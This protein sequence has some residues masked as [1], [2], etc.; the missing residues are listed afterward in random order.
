[1]TSYESTRVRLAPHDLAVRRLSLWLLAGWTA[2]IAS[3]SLYPFDVQ[4]R[5]LLDAVM[6]G[7]PKLREWRDP[8]QR[9]TIV[10]LL[11]YLP[12]GLL[13]SMALEKSR[14][15]FIR[16]LWPVCAAAIVSLA[17]E[18]TQHALPVRDPSLA[19][20]VFNNVSA[21]LGTLV[22][23]LYSALPVQPLSRRLQRLTIGPAPALLVALWLVAHLAPFVPRLR[24]GRIEAAIETSLAMPFEAGK[25]FGFF[26][27]YLVLGTLLNA[28]L[29]RPYFWSALLLSFGV[30]LGAR[31]LFVGQHL[32]PAEGAALVLSLVAIA[33]MR[34]INPGRWASQAFLFACL[35]LFM[36]GVWPSSQPFVTSAEGILWLPFAELAGVPGDSGALPLLERLFLGIGLA[37]L[38]LQGVL[39]RLPP[40]PFVILIAISTEFLQ[41][42]I[43]G[44][45]PDT[46]DIAALLI[47]AA[48]AQAGT[49]IDP[50][51]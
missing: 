42:W 28:L 15:T 2:L 41:Q 36:G 14:S 1:V 26:A 23:A 33:I 47:G 4:P 18:V 9:D 31:L 29:R 3:A 24:P 27:C 38:A 10:N 37:W 13:G 51:T 12:L 35:A 39:R 17:V 11:L 32:S 40:L 43:P 34:K 50:R 44:R 45:L 25:M 21:G 22:A 49:K 20:W 30:S 16:I 6:S 8:S 19:D 48:L 5:L 7:L 46:T